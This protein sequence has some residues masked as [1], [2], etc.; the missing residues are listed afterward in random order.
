MS[1]I[2]VQRFNIFKKEAKKWLTALG[3]HRYDTYFMHEKLDHC[4]EC[5][6]DNKAHHSILTLTTSI[7]MSIPI[8]DELI[9]K[10]ALHE[11]LELLLSKLR[12][13]ANQK[14]KTS[15]EVD[16]LIHEVIQSLINTLL[17]GK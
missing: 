11:V 2:S 7:D 3:L 10:L 9:K 16:A 8:N 5:H 4:A 1:K 6:S 12:D 14:N 17:Q 13:A 15:D